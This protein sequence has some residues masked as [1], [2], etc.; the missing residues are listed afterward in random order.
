MKKSI[1]AFPSLLTVGNM[2]CGFLAIGYATQGLFNES[3]WFI[4]FAMLF[5]AFDGK[6]ARVARVTTDFGGQLD[7]LADMISFG[8]APALLV[9][10][11]CAAFPNKIVLL[12]TAAYV[13]CAGMRLARFNVENA[14]DEE[15]H[16]YFKGLPTPAAAGMLASLVTLHY[17][18]KDWEVELAVIIRVLP[19]VTL[20]L[21]TLMISK[22][23]YVHI[24][25]MLKGQWPFEYL[26]EI[27]FLFFFVVLTKPYS[28]AIL[29]AGYTVSGILTEARVRVVALI[30]DV[31]SAS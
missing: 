22:I 6:L 27:V 15:H 19:F 9:M 14:P 31:R 20:L 12:F 18:L 24:L 5:D 26:V 1:A 16:T 3:A 7:S 28:L 29:F 23:R 17:D 11:L 2:L 21:A 4:L 25:H 10:R 8:V 13:T 30:K